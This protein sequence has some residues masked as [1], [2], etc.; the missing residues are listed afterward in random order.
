MLVQ[1][2]TE[3]AKFIKTIEKVKKE[4]TV[5]LG[6]SQ[7]LVCDQAALAVAI[8]E[9]LVQETKDVYCGVELQNGLTRGQ[10]VIDWRCHLKKP[11]NLRLILGIDK[12]HFYSMIYQALQD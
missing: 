12:E 2:P 3:K 11:P 6:Y 5:R 4:N 1:T 10:S 8:N 7:Y 9:S